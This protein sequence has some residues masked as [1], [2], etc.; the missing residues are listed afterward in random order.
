MSN[1]RDH[2]CP[3]CQ[4]PPGFPCTDRRG[5]FLYDRTASGRE[6]RSHGTRIAVATPTEL[7]PSDLDEA[8]G[9]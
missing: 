6:W 7:E 8:L 2:T 3:T 4:A 1:P 5:R 9:Y